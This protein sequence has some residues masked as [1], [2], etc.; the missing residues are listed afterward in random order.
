M[1]KLLSDYIKV[2]ERTLSPERCQALIERFEAAPDLH[3]RKA[4]D[5]S[6]SFM[7]LSVSRHWKDV[8]AEIGQI[9]IGCIRQYWKS[10]EIGPYWPSKPVSEELRLAEK[11]RVWIFNEWREGLI[12]APTIYQLGPSAV[13]DAKKAKRIL[14]VLVEH[15]WLAPEIGG[16]LVGG[17]NRREAWR[18]RR[19]S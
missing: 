1:A 19:G 6:Y 14:E 17:I 11:V 2:Y 5:G 9:I 10:L 7:Q 16:G 13:R 8:E 3:E 4:E 18:I 12:A 15:G